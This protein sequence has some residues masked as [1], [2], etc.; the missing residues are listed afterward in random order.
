MWHTVRDRPNL[1]K[2]G[3]PRAKVERHQLRDRVPGNSLLEMGDVW[4]EL[5]QLG[6]SIG[7]TRPGVG[8]PE[9]TKFAGELIRNWTEIRQLLGRLPP[10]AAVAL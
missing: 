7:R 9:T 2:G 8:D 3:Q 6:G 10:D 5:S 1:D 4:P